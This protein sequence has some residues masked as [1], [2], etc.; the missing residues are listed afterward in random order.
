MRGSSGST[1]KVNFVGGEQQRFYRILHYNEACAS[2]Q[3]GREMRTCLR[4]AVLSELT[5]PMN[6]GRL[7]F[8]T[9]GLLSMR[10]QLGWQQAMKTEFWND[11]LSPINSP[12]QCAGYNRNPRCYC[13]CSRRNC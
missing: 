7:T 4:K 8:Q 6:K 11:L 10:F 5:L 13:G 2:V 1:I 9:L 12:R 3:R